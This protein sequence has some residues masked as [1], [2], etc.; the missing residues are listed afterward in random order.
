MK[1]LEFIVRGRVVDE[2]AATRMLASNKPKPRKESAAEF[3]RGWRVEGHP[4]GHEEACES[5]AR[6]AWQAW[7]QLSDKERTGQKAPQPWDADVWARTAR[8]KPVL[9][10]FEVRAAA[11]EAVGLAEKAGWTRVRVVELSRGDTALAQQ[12]MW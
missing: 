12:Q 6:A 10:T 2:L 1:G 5:E 9:R 8:R 7:Q 4:P 11:F 3:H